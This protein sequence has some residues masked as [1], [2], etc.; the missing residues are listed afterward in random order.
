MTR[1]DFPIFDRGDL[2]FLDSAASSQKPASVLKAMDD[3]YRV[4]YANVHRGAYELSAVSTDAYEQARKNVAAFIGA[5]PEEVVFTRGATTGLNMLAFRW[6]RDRLVPGDKIVL[7]IAEHHANLVPWQMAAQ[8]TGAE[9]VFAP[10]DHDYQI[11]IDAL[12]GLID[13]TVKIVSITGM[14]NVL[15]S[16]PPIP[17]IA[18]MTHAVGATLIVDGAQL[19]PHAPVDVRTL[20]ADALVFSGHKMLGPTGIGVLWATSDLLNA[21]EPFEGGG[22]MI[23]T[24]S[25]QSS[26]WAAIPQKHEAGTPPFVQAVGLSAAVDYLRAYGMD[27]V[28]AHDMELT[29]YALDKLAQRA[30]I[31]VYGPRNVERRGGAVAFTMDGVHPH[32]L[33]TIL[34]EHGVAIRAG[35]HCARPLMDHLGVPATARMSFYLYNTTADVDQL[36][37][38]LDAAGSIFGIE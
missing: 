22:D 7:S 2:A 30:D 24:V 28:R 14:S 23:E 6:G 20:G 16:M 8:R 35:N 36:L 11:D 21:M 12:A 10:L 18:E 38:A 34:D 5:P 9:L 27:N 19:V 17:I 4:A 13:D 29:A 3:M 1:S 26:T 31:T 15:G 32:D 25:L 33:A 37:E